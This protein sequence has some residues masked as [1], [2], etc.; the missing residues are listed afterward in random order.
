MYNFGRNRG[1]FINFVEIGGKCIMQYWLKGDGCPCR[2]RPR[3]KKNYTKSP[4]VDAHGLYGLP[5]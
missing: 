2:Y 5:T 1:N 4:E 3:A